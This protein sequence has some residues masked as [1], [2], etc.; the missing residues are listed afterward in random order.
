MNYNNT[1][2]SSTPVKTPA[3]DN[4][5]TEQTLAPEQTD[6][7]TALVTNVLLPRAN[8]FK[9][10][11]FARFVHVLYVYMC[12]PYA[13]FGYLFYAQFVSNIFKA[14]V[15]GAID[16]KTIVLYTWCLFYALSKAT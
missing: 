8:V 12:L 7:Y 9:C 5:T 16:F 6:E 2:V 10:L 15:M 4:F 11:L 13:Q 14:T 3:M 1:L